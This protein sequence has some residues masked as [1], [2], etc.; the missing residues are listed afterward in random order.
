MVRATF[1]A[2]APQATLPLRP[3][4]AARRVPGTSR[5]PTA[6]L[7]GRVLPVAAT[8]G[9]VGVK[10]VP[11]TRAEVRPHRLPGARPVVEATAGHGPKVEEEDARVA[12]PADGKQ[13][14]IA[15]A[16]GGTHLRVVRTPSPV[17]PP[18]KGAVALPAVRV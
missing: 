13:G 18:M 10:V 11:T 3:L 15:V 2:G 5:T 12:A 6:V 1:V 14:A 4:V 9:Q 8:T 16:K 7:A 17:G